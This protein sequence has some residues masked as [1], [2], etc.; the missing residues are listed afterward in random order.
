MGGS[1]ST[2][3]AQEVTKEGCP[4]AGMIIQSAP[5]SAFR[6]VLRVNGGCSLPLDR[7]DT[8]RAIVDIGCT[9]L[10]IHGDQD[11]VVPFW[12]GKE[13]HRLIPE[14]FRLSPLWVKGAGH[15]DVEKI[16][17]RTGVLRDRLR[18]FFQKDLRRAE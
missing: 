2:H 8:G 11:A 7:L 18:V 13:I 6:V 16:G 17:F 1:V 3:L 15:N 4:P 14:R 9:T 12:H 5:L 10:V